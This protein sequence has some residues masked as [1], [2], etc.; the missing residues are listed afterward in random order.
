M[1]ERMIVCGHGGCNKVSYPPG[2][3]VV[4]WR[5]LKPTEPNTE[6]FQTRK[7]NSTIW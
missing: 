1:S 7:C 3:G 6:S 5:G 2:V 4:A